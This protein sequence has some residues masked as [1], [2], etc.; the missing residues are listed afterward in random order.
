M[1]EF[2]KKF[3]DKSYEMHKNYNKEWYKRNLANILLAFR[4][5]LH[6]TFRK[7]LRNNKQNKK[8]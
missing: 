2:Y 6:K 1:S 8:T 4:V 7:F 5:A 3:L